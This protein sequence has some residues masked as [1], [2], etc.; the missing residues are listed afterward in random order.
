[1]NNKG[2]EKLSR[3]IEAKILALL[4]D[5]PGKWIFM[6]HG[7][8]LRE[9]VIQR[10][11][12][13]DEIKKYFPVKSKDKEDRKD[14]HEKL[15]KGIIIHSLS[16]IL[17][18]QRELWGIAKLADRTAAS[19][20]RIMEPEIQRI[21]SYSSGLIN[22][23][24]P[25]I[26]FT[27]AYKKGDIKLEELVNLYREYIKKFTDTLRCYI[28][29]LK[30]IHVDHDNELMIKTY[31]YHLLYTSLPVIWT[32]ITKGEFVG[33]ADTRV[34][35]HLLIDHL[36]ATASATNLY[37]PGDDK[38][39]GGLLVYIGFSRLRE[40]LGESRKL[41]DLWVSSWLA[42]VMIWYAIKDLVWCLGP[43]IVLIPSQ[44][45][46]H[47]YLSLLKKKLEELNNGEIPSF[48]ED[49]WRDI[50][51]FYYFDEYHQYPV[52]AWQPAYAYMLLPLNINWEE[53]KEELCHGEELYNNNR[54]GVDDPFETIEYILRCRIRKAWKIVVETALQK[55]LL[56]K[57]RK[58]F[59]SEDLGDI[60]LNI[61]EYLKD[62][63]KKP[64]LNEIIEAGKILIDRE[65]LR[66]KID[67]RCNGKKDRDRIYCGFEAVISYFEEDIGDTIGRDFA[68]FLREYGK[69]IVEI[70]YSIYCNITRRLN[71]KKGKGKTEEEQTED[72]L[73]IETIIK[74][75]YMFTFHKVM[76]EVARKK[77]SAGS[78]NY[79]LNNLEL[80]CKLWR[81]CT[82]CGWR[83]AIFYVPGRITD[84][85]PNEEYKKF[86]RDMDEYIREVC[87]KQCR[88]CRRGEEWRDIISIFKPGEKLC[89]VDLVKRLLGIPCI[90]RL[91]AEKLLGYTPPEEEWEP[92]FPSTD[93]LAALATKLSLARLARLILEKISSDR[94]PKKSYSLFK[95]IIE[96][97][98]E[99]CDKICS[100]KEP[101]K[102]YVIG[103]YRRRR[104]WLPRL[105][106]REHGDLIDRLDK[107]V[108][109]YGGEEWVGD[110]FKAVQAVLVFNRRGF[111]DWFIPG[112]ADAE[113]SHILRDIADI[114][115]RNEEYL[116]KFGREHVRVF[117]EA[118]R[119]P[120]LYY[121]N[122]WFDADKM[123]FTLNGLLFKGIDKKMHGVID[124]SDYIVDLA[125]SVRN[126]L[127][128]RDYSTKA[129]EEA[130]VRTVYAP[131]N[132]IAKNVSAILVSPSY[133]AAISHSLAITLYTAGILAEDLGGVAVY[134]TGDE[135]LVQLPAWLPRIFYEH[136]R[137]N[138]EK[139]ESDSLLHYSAD[140]P[141]PLYAYLIRRFFWGADTENPSSDLFKFIGDTRGF[142]E[143]KLTIKDYKKAIYYVP[144]LVSNGLSFSLRASH[145]R[146]H[147]RSELSLTQYILK[148][149]KKDGD[150]VGISYGRLQPR[151]VPVQYS[152]VS[153]RNTTTSSGNK[154]E[155]LDSVGRP[156]GILLKYLG[157]IYPSL[158]INDLRYRLSSNFTRDLWLMFHQDT[159][160]SLG[161]DKDFQ[162][163][164]LWMLIE[165]NINADRDEDK[166][167]GIEDL[168]KIGL[169]VIKDFE[170]SLADDILPALQMMYQAIRSSRRM[171]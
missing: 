115:E 80:N 120:R 171:K 69:P 19:F 119:K 147:L 91:V 146:D 37:L 158:A 67:K 134:L 131:L 89:I 100:I 44:R 168:H 50:I 36:W 62:V 99:L 38:D 165:R 21:V 149:V 140:S 127:K 141:G 128:E 65:A 30:D 130:I 40:W 139:M 86:A 125:R 126:V 162:E 2:E 136:R 142:H 138:E 137:L 83:P 121:Y 55:N 9:Q 129:V 73:L 51:K 52:H 163:K 68:E 46:N 88:G 61:S 53:I 167:R 70:V 41:S 117:I 157:S 148:K 145:Y 26:F 87:G 43:D 25:E 3:L 151:L 135:G 105:L 13:E 33:P 17:E 169:E 109:E 84:A 111:Y 106:D 153:L 28:R 81:H 118:L 7:A 154:S 107:L 164:A 57:I 11:V 104:P 63:V 39:V 94:D 31:A 72:S 150:R 32:K 71:K 133:H 122:I 79:Y 103:Y 124:P 76:R 14:S 56:Y 27:R 101:G 10:I 144:A 24:D 23:F 77:G 78:R 160:E 110:L 18:K 112:M 16:C 155:L 161:R 102:D 4:H 48:L 93:D 152:Y 45:W 97:L 170:A 90:F 132:S 8:K 98:V 66:E 5:P 58:Y 6:E 108:K 114:L 156:L 20:D 113:I 15:A 42:T 75:L 159:I 29:P 95:D 116:N 12:S 123:G 35:H 49:I 22:P 34:P 143:V 64:P 85:G 60:G 166:R 74:F 59:K 47:H 82:V 96:K 92:S 54:L 1:M